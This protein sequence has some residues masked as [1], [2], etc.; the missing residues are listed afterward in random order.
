M[1]AARGA[2]GRGPLTLPAWAAG[3][4]QAEALVAAFTAH[5]LREHAP[6]F[7]AKCDPHP[8]GCLDWIGAR[9]SSGYGVFKLFG[10]AVLVHRL[11]CEALH[12]CERGKPLALHASDRPCC[13]SPDHLSW[14]TSSLNL[15][16]QFQRQRRTR[17]QLRLRLAE[18]A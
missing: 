8:D 9:N 13:C 4:P 2:A 6:R 7:L 16:H 18:V 1:A 14:G 15:T 5:G 12:R 3:H 10:R 11:V 17:P